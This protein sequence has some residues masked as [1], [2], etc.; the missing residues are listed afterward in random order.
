MEH[1]LVIWFKSFESMQTER[2]CSA[3]IKQLPLAYGSAADYSNLLVLNLQDYFFFYA[4][5]KYNGTKINGI[6]EVRL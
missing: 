3:V 6:S 2:R 4:V 1:M 5:C